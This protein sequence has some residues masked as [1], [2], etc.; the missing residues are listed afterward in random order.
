MAYLARFVKK[1]AEIN[2]KMDTI[3]AALQRP[4]ASGVNILREDHL[5]EDEGE[6]SVIGGVQ[7]IDDRLTYETPKR[8]RMRF[9]SIPFGWWI[10][11]K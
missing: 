2:R 7:A 3:L 5:E 10:L 8:G 4:D 1:V 6:T 9:V 11:R